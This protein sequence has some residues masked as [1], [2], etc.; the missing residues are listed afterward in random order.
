LLFEKAGPV[1]YSC[2]SVQVSSEGRGSEDNIRMMIGWTGNAYDQKGHRL[3]AVK[4][5]AGDCYTDGEV[6][7]KHKSMSPKQMNTEV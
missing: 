1:H 3:K 2:T 7:T 6:H 4:S 5:E